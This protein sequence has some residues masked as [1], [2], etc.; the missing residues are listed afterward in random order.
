MDV[1]STFLQ[2]VD[3]SY[4]TLYHTMS[5]CVYSGWPTEPLSCLLQK[6]FCINNMPVTIP[7]DTN[8]CQ[9]MHCQLCFWSCWFPC[10][11]LKCIVLI[12][13]LYSMFLFCLYSNSFCKI[14]LFSKIYVGPWCSPSVHH[15][16][17]TSCFSSVLPPFKYTWLW[18]SSR[19]QTEG[20]IGGWV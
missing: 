13:E 17:E 9:C 7:S 18:V 5:S 16:S 14:I 11:Y 8:I 3:A 2:L 10:R 12:Y 20:L 15:V 1:W 19:S 4:L 6:V